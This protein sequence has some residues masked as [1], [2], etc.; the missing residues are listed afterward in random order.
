M[1]D[2]PSKFEVS[3]SG[4]PETML[5]PL[6]NRAAE[7]AR[8]DRLIDDP[9]A[10]D[11]VSQINYDF[12]GTFG[13][14]NVLHAVRARICDDLM[15]GFADRHAGSALVVALGE[16]LD[17]QYWRIGNEGLTW[18]SVD[19]PEAIE[20]RNRLLPQIS[21]GIQV[22]QSAMDLSWLEAVP[23]DRPIFI[24]AAGLLMYFSEN[25][26]RRLL[27]EIAARF[28]GS[29]IYFDTITPYVSAM[30][31]KGWRITKKYT[32]P[33]MPWGIHLEDIPTFV[34]TS[35]GD[36]EANIINY[37]RAFPKRTRLYAL[38]S[39]IS[40]IRRRY[41]GGLVHIHVPPQ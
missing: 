9:L 17:T 2:R 1:K 6:W 34:R 27:S 30:T 23:R 37:V 19:L 8:K 31:M 11:L 10:R 15:R 21:D 33:E 26:V 7:A 41:A 3:L 14:P 24:T 25:D 32:T 39:Q 16:G 13:K 36:C 5:W 22:A 40:F 18:V 12:R 4:V 35:M 29:E 38:L 20:L 28:P